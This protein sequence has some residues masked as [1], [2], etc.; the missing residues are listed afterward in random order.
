MKHNE[1]ANAM[2]QLERAINAATKIAETEFTYTLRKQG[3][4]ALSDEWYRAMK[5][6]EAM[7][8]IK[9]MIHVEW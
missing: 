7:T 6:L 3:C 2:L 4:D 8:Q 1:F 5:G 9:C